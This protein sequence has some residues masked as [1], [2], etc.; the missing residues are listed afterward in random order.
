VSRPV[1]RYL[2][3]QIVADLARK[4]V[5]V[6]GPRQVGKTRL[7]QSIVTDPR[8]Y[9]SFDV[10]ED[11]T[12]ILRNDLPA[13]DTLFFDE[14]HHHRGWRG[15]LK[16]IFDSGRP[17]RHV[18]VTG[19]A[20]LDFYR[21][22]GDSLQGR[23]F[24]LRLHPLSFAEVGGA[25][26]GD[27][28]TLLELSGFPEP[29]FGADA[30]SARRWSAAYR[31]RMVRE[32]VASLE[33]I[34]D[35]NKLELLSLTLPERVGSPLSINSMREDLGVSHPTLTRWLDVLERLYAIFRVPPFG[36]PR[37]RALLKARK[38]YHYD[39]TIVPDPAARF[40][41]LVASHLLKWA[42]YQHDTQGRDVGLRYFR[43]VDGR[44]VDFI[45]TD[46][47]RPVGAV[48]CKWDDAPI[49][50]G[51][52]YFSARFPDVPAWQVS[53]VGKRDYISREGIRV[54]PA[55]KLLRDLV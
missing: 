29:F 27:L 48:E 37:L 22:G 34:T 25:S 35:L 16:G 54:A 41:N 4:M 31:V 52:L 44:E 9:L 5:F 53:A 6:G 50:P 20:R 7:G 33:T 17:T 10:P 8:A 43:D 55:I 40:E 39:W 46:G 47:R 11:R 30:S 51:L 3:A 26:A 2:R 38:H 28:R 36:A 1:H 12:A 18:L 42:E 23:Y 14:L 19:S 32:D 45:L 24:H 21:Y 49:S 13:V 15:L